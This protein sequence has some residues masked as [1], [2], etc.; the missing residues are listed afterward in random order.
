MA[1]LSFAN[2]VVSKVEEGK[3]PFY[4]YVFVFLFAITARNFLEVFAYQEVK[5]NDWYAHLHYSTYYVAL[6]AALI[7]ITALLSNSPI[8]KIAKLVL[9]FIPIIIICP[10]VDLVA[11]HAFSLPQTLG[12][13]SP[14]IHGNFFGEYFTFFGHH[15]GD[16]LS[17]S[18]PNFGPS[19]GYRVEVFFVLVG[20][21][22]LLYV[23]TKNVARTVLGLMVLYTLI[24]F[25][26]STPYVLKSLLPG[27]YGPKLVP[28]YMLIGL[29]FLLIGLGRHAPKKVGSIVKDSRPF[30]MLFYLLLFMFG[31]TWGL[32]E[33][34]MI[35]SALIFPGVFILISIA[36][37]WVYSVMTNN[38]QDVEIDR[39]SNPNRPLVKGEPLELEWYKQAAWFVFAITLTFALYADVVVL[40]F[41]SIYLLSY[42]L[43]S[44]PP[45]Q[46]KRLPIIS[47][48]PIA[49]N[50]LLLLLL[51]LNYVGKPEVMTWEILIFVL[52]GGTLAL[53][54]I[55]IKDRE[56]DKRAGIKTLPVL[57]GLKQAKFLIGLVFLI[58]HGF[59]FLFVE[60]TNT[61]FIL[62]AMGLL[63]FY[64]ITR[65][66]YSD[67]WV[68]GLFTTA[69]LVAII[70]KFL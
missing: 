23:K 51:G 29:V 10:L 25:F 7:W 5:L 22:F 48:F 16:N 30:R 61:Y 46:F 50:V 33:G 27:K 54:V 63:Q 4:H 34:G 53:N 2:Q 31:T 40:F 65:K 56:G 9:T 44:C 55:D 11:L 21:G 1:L 3:S 52:V 12:Y 45:I 67:K 43:Y 68:V 66:D 41:I 26:C 6:V 38:I 47:K 39:V 14:E 36:G 19:I 20:L 18:K 35:N 59:G 70:E 24:Y 13:L 15:I 8:L 57:L 58:G 64:L 17:P 62:L 60:S 37:A 32:T 49:I 28:Y 42:F 69:I